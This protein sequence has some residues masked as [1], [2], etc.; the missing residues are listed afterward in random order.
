MITEHVVVANTYRDSVALMQLSGRIRDSEGVTDAVLVMMTPANLAM[1]ESVGIDTSGIEPKP[2]DLLVLVSGNDAE[3]VARALDCARAALHESSLPGGGAPAQ[4]EPARSIRM[5]RERLPESNL[6]VV[7]TPG[8]YAS[9]E[10]EKALRLGLNVMIFSDGIALDEE[11]RLKQ[12][13][14]REQ[15][16][17][18][19]PDCG[20]AVI[21]GVPL[22]FA[23]NVRPG[24]V[25]IVGASGTG[26]QAVMCGVDNLGSGIS[27]AIG[28][29][30]HD[31][32]QRIGG[33]SMLRG[34]DLLGKDPATDI[35]VLVSKPPSPSIATRVVDTAVATGK[36]VVVCFLG[37]DQS[38]P[39]G[40]HRAETLE[41]AAL[42]AVGLVD[43]RERRLEAELPSPEVSFSSSQAFVRGLYSGGTLCYEATMLAGRALGAVHSNTPVP[44]AVALSDPWTSSGHTFVDLG[45]DAFTRGRPHPMI[46]HSLRNERLVSEARAADCAVILFDVVLGHGSHEDPAAAMLDAV[47]QAQGVASDAGR[48][49][50]LVA[51][52][53]GTARD[54]QG[55]HR[56]RQAFTDMGVHVALSHRNAVALAVALARKAERSSDA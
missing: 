12:L 34:I 31:L 46:D 19:G 48:A 45:D 53:V 28:T 7:S 55:L 50:P 3:T 29:G 56:Q 42:M 51:V 4:Q 5:A 38:V 25:G 8:D 52:M 47:S 11:L 24:P 2:T 20:T 49:L 44:P 36:P 1:L 6:V 17:V 10:A 21:G 54:P 33:L 37:A 15:L 40:A 35:I 13:A 23:N 26:M 39:A 9:Y 18:M 43:G 16:L 30:G 22:A 14:E 27:H 32:H 41:E